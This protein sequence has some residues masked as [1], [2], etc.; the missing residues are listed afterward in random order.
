MH[1]L[2]KRQLKRFDIG[3]E[4]REQIAPFLEVINQAHN[5]NDSDIRHLEKIIV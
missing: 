2:L 1:R 5:S 3:L 4:T